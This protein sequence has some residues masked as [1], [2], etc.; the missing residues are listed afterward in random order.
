MKGNNNEWIWKLLRWLCPTDRLEEI[1]GDLIQQH[2]RDVQEFG[3]SRARWL[4]F[5]TTLKYMRP[6]IIFRK[7][8]SIS[9]ASV[10]MFRHHLLVA[11]RQMKRNIGLTS[12]HVVGIAVGIAA[13]ILITAYLAFEFNFD[14]FHPNGTQIYRVTTEYNTPDGDRQTSAGTYFGVGD[15]LKEHFSQVEHVV[16]FYQ[17]P[18]NTGL[19]FQAEGRVF[20]ER[21]YLFSESQF[22]EVFPAFLEQGSASTCLVNQTSAVVSKDLA[23]RMFGTT[24]VLGKTIK[25]LDLEDTWLT[26]TGILA[27]IPMNS[28]LQLDIV[29]PYDNDW[30]PPEADRWNFP[31]NITYVALAKNAD[32]EALGAQLTSSLKGLRSNGLDRTNSVLSLQPLSEVHF[33]SF[34]QNELGPNSNKDVLFGVAAIAVIILLITWMNYVNIE[35]SRFLGKLKEVGVRRLIGSGRAQ[36]V[37]QISTYFFAVLVFALLLS[38]V[39][40]FVGWDTFSSITNVSWP[41]VQEL[42][43][44]TWIMA[45]S[46]LLLG[47]VIAAIYPSFFITSLQPVDCMQGKVRNTRVPRA[48]RVMLIFQIAS[49][50]VLAAFLVVIF[51]QLEFMRDSKTGVTLDRV[52]VAYNPTSYSIFDDSAKTERAEAFQRQ[53]MNSPFF[54]HV[55]TSSVVPGEPIGFTYHNLTKRNLADP[56][57]NVPYKVVF[58]DDQYID[59]YQLKLLGGR[60]YSTERTEDR[61]HKTIILNERAIKTLGFTSAEEALGAEIQF[62]VTF[63]WE[64]YTIVG[65][66][67]DHSHESIKVPTYPTVYFF[68]NHTAQMTYYSMR[69]AQGADSKEAI[70]FAAANWKSLWPGK[71]FDYYFA[72][73]RYDQQFK[74]EVRLSVISSLFS[75]VA[76][77]LAGLGVFGVAMLESR[78]RLKEISIRRVLGAS[79]AMVVSTLS[80]DLLR[81]TAVASIIAIPII[82]LV[83]TKWLSSYAV[84][85]NT[86]LWPYLLPIASMSIVLLTISIAQ[87]VRAANVNPTQYLKSD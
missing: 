3:P 79:V 81:V 10:S 80:R 38:S 60:S 17:W 77:F 54:E 25:R 47:S 70:E 84:Q 55:S 1:E 29:V 36:L 87:F 7:H 19:V 61:E 23:L 53:L 73:Q 24:D 21:N 39:L 42:M 82:S 12:I 4:L 63:D 83:T 27:D 32:A 69:L 22:F 37:M 16:R 85:V 59:T 35:S 13:F 41:S 67:A 11:I 68:A 43:S 26:I 45:F 14:R 74:S 30:V 48:K 15:Y 9:S 8:F 44:P 76:L 6:D 2:T 31:A 20:N 75:G 50:L 62:M 57:D 5:S 66:L 51:R 58:V 64:K 52:L 28:H 65:V 49:S 46:V 33:S 86:G 72:D 40:L 56:D 78:A 18:A 34:D 71:S